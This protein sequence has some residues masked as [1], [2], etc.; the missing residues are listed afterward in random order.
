MTGVPGQPAWLPVLRIGGPG[1]AREGAE[2]VR[3]ACGR[4]GLPAPL[5]AGG[6]DRRREGEGGRVH[7]AAAGPRGRPP[8]FAGRGGPRD[9]AG[10]P[11]AGR[12]LL[13]DRV[14]LVVME[15][16]SDYWRILAD[17]VLP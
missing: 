5:R 7:A 4:R 3:A 9:G 17:L 16:T 11:G 10:G 14:E 2:D 12:W 13:A 15:A 6:G 1:G 8:G